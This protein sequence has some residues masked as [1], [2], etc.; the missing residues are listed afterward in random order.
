MLLAFWWK[1]NL[2]ARCCYAF[3]LSSLYDGDIICAWIGA[4]EKIQRLLDVSIW[5]EVRMLLA[6]RAGQHISF[7]EDMFTR[8][9][10]FGGNLQTRSTEEISGKFSNYS[11]F[12]WIQYGHPNP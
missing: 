8:S 10:I 5:G 12:L 6:C 9:H 4:W 11:L 2:W 7:L 1:H 3:L